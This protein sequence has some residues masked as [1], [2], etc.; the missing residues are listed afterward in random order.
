MPAARSGGAGPYRRGA[1]FE[2]HVQQ[3]LESRGWNTLRAAGSKGPFDIV[4][5]PGNTATFTK[6]P[7]VVFI[8]CKRNGQL[9][10]SERDKMTRAIYGIQVYLYVVVPDGG[11]LAVRN[12]TAWEHRIWRH[13]EEVL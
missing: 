5:W 9:L 6:A 2:R 3:V 4:A 13:F 7:G 12:V 10:P 11:G 1:A 8:Q